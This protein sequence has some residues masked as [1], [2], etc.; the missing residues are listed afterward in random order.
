MVNDCNF[1]TVCTDD[2]IR[3]AARI[4][5]KANEPVAQKLG[6]TRENAPTNPAFITAE[7]LKQQLSEKR[8]FY[9][10]VRKNEAIGTIAIE[11]APENN[12]LYYI[13]RLAVLPEKQGKGYGRLLVQFAFDTIRERGGTSTSVAIINENTGLKEWYSGLGFC[14][15]GTR[16]FD[17]LPFT[18][19]FMEKAL[20]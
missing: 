2:D 3:A 16:R 9:M 11:K 20:A 8:D 19:C 1:Q 15:T 5:R 7:K 14:E 6:F 10:M 12:T 18:V 13:E 4:L 17:H